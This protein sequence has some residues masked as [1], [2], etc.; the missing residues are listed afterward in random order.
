MFSVN[1]EITEIS[2]MA[3]KEELNSLYILENCFK[4]LY[5][6]KTQTLSNSIVSIFLQLNIN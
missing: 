2:K 3:I 5:L 4:V 1:R 6:F